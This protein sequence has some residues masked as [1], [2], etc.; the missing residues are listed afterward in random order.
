MTNVGLVA[1][2]LVAMAPNLLVLLSGLIVVVVRGSRMPGKARALALVGLGV[3]LFESVLSVA[4][5]SFGARALGYATGLSI[6]VGVLLNLVGAGG[7]ALVIA[8]TVSRAAPTPPVGPGGPGGF[9]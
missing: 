9:G 1:G 8:S 7:L 6:A 4:W 3:L 2:Q 5:Y